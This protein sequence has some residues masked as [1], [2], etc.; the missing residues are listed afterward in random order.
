MASNE[1]TKIGLTILIFVILSFAFLTLRN[2]SMTVN[3]VYFRKSSCIIINHTDRI[4]EDIEDKFRSELEIKTI[5]LDHEENL[6]DYE[7][8]LLKKYQVIGIPVII[9]NGKEY[10]GEFTKEE[11]E[12]GI[13]RRFL[14]NPE[15]CK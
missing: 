6:T 7:N 2:K 10:R 9:I 14:I 12:K 11:I 1:K 13:C 4:I 5:D 3:V 8:N 15:A